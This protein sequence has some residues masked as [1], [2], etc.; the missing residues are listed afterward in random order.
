MVRV[1]GVPRV[2][3]VAGT[4]LVG[5]RYVSKD[6]GPLAGLRIDGRYVFY[7]ISQS[8]GLAAGHVGLPSSA[9]SAIVQIEGW[10]FVAVT[11]AAGDFATIAPVGNTRFVAS[12]P[13][14][15]L[16][17]E[18]TAQVTTGAVAAANINLSAQATTAA[19]TPADGAIHVATST[20]IEITATAPLRVAPPTR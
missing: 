10:P 11:D 8:W 20:Q 14:T 13:R 7:R 9:T 6:L 2:V 17:G 15:S 19:V 3:A 16:S 5:D 1:D 4:D 12:V 18:T